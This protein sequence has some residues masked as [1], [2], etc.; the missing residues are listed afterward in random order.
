MATVDLGVAREEAQYLHHGCVH[1]L[2]SALKEPAAAAEKERVAREDDP[3]VVLGDVVADVT[4]GMAGSEQ[5]GDLDTSNIELVPVLDMP[6]L[7]ALSHLLSTFY[8]TW[9]D[10]QSSRPPRGQ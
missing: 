7:S 8:L 4:R 6:A 10:P 3:V 2:G 5:T 1:H 9:S